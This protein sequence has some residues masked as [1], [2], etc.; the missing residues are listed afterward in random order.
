LLSFKAS[1]VGTLLDETNL[2]VQAK[3]SPLDLQR[4]KFINA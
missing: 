3:I 1:K 2:E 4:Q